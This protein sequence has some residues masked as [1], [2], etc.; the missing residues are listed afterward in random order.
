M[1]QI[2][3]W[4]RVLIWA[5]CA[6]GILCALPNGFYARVE[7]RNDAVAALET[8]ASGNGLEE[9]AAQWPSF[10]PSS[11]V[12]LGLDLRGGAH[13]L[14]EVQVADVYE[15]RLE[16]MWPEVRDLLREE[17]DTIGTIRLQKTEGAELRVRLNQKPDQVGAAAELVRGLA[18]PVVSLSG[19]GATDIDV[20]VDGADIVVTLS[21]A[22]RV[23]TD[24]RTVA[25]SLEIIRRR[26]DEVGTREP[27]IQRQGSDRIL[28]QVP[29]IGSASEL[30]AIIGTTAQLTF[31]PVVTRT[32]NA[33][34][35]AGAGNELLP[36]L[37]TE[38]E[39]YV[40][41]QVPVV[42]G[43]EL[44]DAQPAFDQN[45]RPAVNFRFN[46]T[47]ARK[48]GDYTAENIGNPFAIVLDGEVISAP[49]I[50]SHIPG[51]SGII[52]GNFTVEESTN[53]AV[54]LRAGA[55]PAG[56][57]FLEER[58]IGPEL[59]AD[60]I[61]AGQIACIVAFVAVL[62]F[63]VLSY[64]LFGLFA[65]IALLVNVA[66]IF[67]A[68]SLIGGTLTLPGIA[69][70]VLTIGMAVDANVLVFE[71]IREELRT[72]KGPARAIELGYDRALSAII[73]ANITTF[74]IAV[75][76]FVMGSGPVKGFAITLG[77]GI[78]TSVFTAI[79]VTRLLI[80][81][82]FER[83]RPKTIEV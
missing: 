65:N 19:A 22:E 14:A 34:M 44:V 66:L 76:L 64:G 36:S 35:P 7:A 71:R 13:L 79:F 54:L 32:S 82:W 12:N 33:D 50:Q 60:S 57:E 1:L 43:E 37:D 42:T 68:L 67:G 10:L 26:I 8:G 29:G 31:Q 20:A 28:I 78:L 46:T 11:L 3:M 74:I 41:E 16:A 81:M 5:V 75:I 72:A 77:L 40:L 63:M 47:G 2:D 38:G 17:R 4:K 48:F 9:Q 39:Y 30:K 58:T 15:S 21:E 53:L 51:G 6:L 23:A 49:V 18:R 25:Q 52:T 61:A 70:I 45:G 73:D 27:T 80:V 24:E 69:G 62:V 59:G 56:L 55:L 83:K